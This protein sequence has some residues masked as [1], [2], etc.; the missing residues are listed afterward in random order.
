MK[1]LFTSDTHVHPG[2][3]DRLLCAANELRP[4]AMIIGGDLIPDWQGSIHASIDPHRKWVGNVLLKRLRE[5]R[6]EFPGVEVFLD[7]GNDDL[8]AARMLLEKADGGDFRLLDRQLHQLAPDLLVVG[9]MA[10]NPTPFLIKDRE[11]ADCR[12][13][14]GWDSDTVRRDGFVTGTGTAVPISLDLSLGTMEDDLEGLTNSLNSP[15]YR[16]RRFILVSHAPP[17]DTALDCIHSGVH[18][19]SLAI[20][21]FIE[22][23]S[24]SGRLLLA[25]HGHI[26][27]S[28][29]RSGL[30]WQQLGNVPCFNIGQKS[31]LLRALLLDPTDPVGSARL[32]HVDRSGSVVEIQ[33]ENWCR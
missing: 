1:I 15:D 31:S 17:S 14:P 3:L 33:M 32:F 18:V 20:R 4:D 25:L 28:P 26:H 11:K 9:Y 13:H 19:G 10:V 21:R 6:H 30:V 22:H 29:W 16:H 27:E 2:H 23:W 7:L 12:N 24:P 5:F 8:A